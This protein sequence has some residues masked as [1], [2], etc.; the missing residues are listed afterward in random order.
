MS[1][2]I[3]LTHA[4]ATHAHTRINNTKILK[5]PDGLGF[6]WP[7]LPWCAGQNVHAQDA[8]RANSSSKA[9]LTLPSTVRADL[10]T[11]KVN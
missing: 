1:L 8:S 10:N 7:W 2:F 4:T 11:I 5:A 3:T 9:A 6:G